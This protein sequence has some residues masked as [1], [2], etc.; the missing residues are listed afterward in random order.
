MKKKASFKEQRFYQRV[1]FPFPVVF[2]NGNVGETVDVSQAGLCVSL[3][4]RVS[5]ARVLSF[6]VEFPFSQ[7]KVRVFGEKVWEK[8][9]DE[10]GRYLVGLRFINPRP[11]DLQLLEEEASR[12]D[13]L[14]DDAVAMTNRARGY[15]IRLKTECDLFDARHKDKKEQ[16]VYFDQQIVTLTLTLTEH[17]KSLYAKFQ[18]FD[19]EE[20]LLHRHY[21]QIML[22]GVLLDNVEVNRH[23]AHK[24]LGYAGDFMLINYYY[25]FYDRWLGCSMFEKLVN[26]YSLNLLISRSVVRRKEYFKNKILSI[27]RARPRVR[28]LSVGSGPARELIE[29]LQENTIDNHFTFVCLDFE[30]ESIRY[31]KNKLEALDPARRKCLTIKYLNSSLMDIVKRDGVVSKEKYDLVYSSGLFDYLKDRMASTALT[32]LFACLNKG[33]ELVITNASTG[34]TYERMYYEMLGGWELIYRTPQDMRRMVEH[35][36]HAKG[37]EVMN[38]GEENS[39]LFLGMKK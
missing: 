30:K 29:M 37:V 26:S 8:M 10:T 6:D 7:K 18:A 11:E 17:L 28:I 31:V 33:G 21:Y 25:D 39:F 32:N 2:I 35:I 5:D 19:H 16:Q 20:Y 4:R 15:L 27:V 22:G 34:N 36:R 1:P 12:R 23:V 14:D 3:E 38:I 13:I 24:P 9:M